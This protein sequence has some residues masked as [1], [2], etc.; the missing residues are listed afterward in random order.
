MTKLV[1]QSDKHAHERCIHLLKLVNEDEQPRMVL[2]EGLGNLLACR[3]KFQMSVRCPVCMVISVL[4]MGAAESYL[5]NIFLYN[6]IYLR[7]PLYTPVV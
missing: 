4:T 1:L 7:I 3:L 6:L 2:T 5:L